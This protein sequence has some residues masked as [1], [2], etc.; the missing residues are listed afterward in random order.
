MIQFIVVL[1]L[2]VLGSE[3]EDEFVQQLASPTESN[4][5]PSAPPL[6]RTFHSPNRM[7]GF[8]KKRLL[9]PFD[10]PPS[11]KHSSSN[12]PTDP[13]DKFSRT[14]ELRSLSL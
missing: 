1:L 12:L 9:T 6:P 5:T 13:N 14:S 11:K 8:S 3:E 10:S 7:L 2:N 4:T